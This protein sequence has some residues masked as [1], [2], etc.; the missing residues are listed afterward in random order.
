MTENPS[1]AVA[2]RAPRRMTGVGRVLVAVYG[3]LALAAAGRSAYQIIDHFSVAPVAFTLS[4]FSALVYIVATVALIAPGRLWY[5]VAWITISIE[6]A[7]VLVIGTLSTFAP[8]VIG[9]DAIDPF[10]EDSTVWSAYGAGYLF[11]PLVLPVL[12]MLWLARHRPVAVS[13][14]PARSSAA[15]RA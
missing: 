10:G 14:E 2:T 3:I 6:L 4:A 12:G 7:G 5:R 15:T 13:A 9:M 11:I 8:S 1:S